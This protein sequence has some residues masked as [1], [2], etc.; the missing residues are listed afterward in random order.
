MVVVYLLA[1]FASALLVAVF[2]TNPSLGSFDTAGLSNLVFLLLPSIALLLSL[3]VVTSRIH[4]RPLRSLVAAGRRVRWRRI[5]SAFGLWLL[6]SVAFEIAAF[7]ALP[8]NYHWNF[9]PARFWPLLLVSVLLIPLQSTAEELLFRGY[10]LQLMGTKFARPWLGLL[11]VSLLFGL[12]HA[13]NPEMQEFGSAFLALYVGVGLVLGLLTLMDQGLELAIGLHA[14]NN[15]YAALLVSFPGSV[16][17]TPTLVKMSEYPVSLM[18]AI[19][20]VSAAVFALIMGRRRGW[21]ESLQTLRRA[22]ST[23]L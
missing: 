5:L 22:H 18:V 14:A 21:G 10:L 15:L 23:R 4:H 20:F 19:W 17:E 2:A 9:D 12:S 11:T 6:L 16:L 7:L 13:A 8:Q 1:S 3:G